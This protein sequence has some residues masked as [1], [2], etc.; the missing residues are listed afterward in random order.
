MLVFLHVAKPLLIGVTISL[1]R[2]DTVNAL[3]RI[4]EGGWRC[5]RCS[6]LLYAIFE[7]S[8]PGFIVL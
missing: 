6:A 1:F 2:A 4:V 7:H 3:V 5:S 8:A